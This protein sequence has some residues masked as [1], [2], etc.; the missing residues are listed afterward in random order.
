MFFWMTLRALES[1]HDNR[2]HTLLITHGLKW[3]VGHQSAFVG[4]AENLV[5]CSATCKGHELWGHEFKFYP[6]MQDRLSLPYRRIK[7]Y[8]TLVRFHGMGPKLVMIM[9]PVAI[10]PW[11]MHCMH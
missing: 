3:L 4:V 1:F 8:G 10:E 9:D 7:T 5:H 6:S 11:L 2:V